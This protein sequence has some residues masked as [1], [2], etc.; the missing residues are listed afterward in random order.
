MKTTRDI[1]IKA[2]LQEFSEYG[3]AGA[4]MQR[5][6][7]RANINKAM[8]YYYFTSK[9][10]L[11]ESI[12]YD[13]FNEIF[14]NLSGIV[15]TGQQDFKKNIVRMIQLHNDFLATKP[16]FPKILMREIH[17]ANPIPHKVIRK[18]VAGTGRQ[19]LDQFLDLIEQAKKEGS[20]RDVDSLQTLW[21]IVGMNLFFFIV[22]PVLEI[23]WE[24]SLEH[25]DIL[26]KRKEAIIDLV[27]YG[28]SPRRDEE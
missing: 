25:P 3:Y 28:L 10:R 19:K 11:F 8:I 27:L 5:I 15:I 17:G 16:E 18:V 23:I 26:A 20:I 14:K 2:S 13:T 9:D 21:N 24:D 12:L 7:D 4:R 6:A 1:I 22:K